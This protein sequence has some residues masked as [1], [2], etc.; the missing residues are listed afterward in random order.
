MFLGI[1]LFQLHSSG[2]Q[3]FWWCDF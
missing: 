1:A 2:I 3:S